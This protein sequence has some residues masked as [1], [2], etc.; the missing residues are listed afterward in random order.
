MDD[1][2]KKIIER[3]G[4]AVPD[5]QRQIM[6][7]DSGTNIFENAG[8]DPRDLSDDADDA[9]WN[10]RMEVGALDRSEDRLKA[11]QKHF[12]DAKPYGDDNFIYT[13]EKGR[14]RQYNK[15]SWLPNLGDFASIAPE[16]GE[17][18]GGAI[19]GVYG[20]AGGG[21]AGS[22]VPAVGT[23]AGTVA[24]AIGGAGAGSVVGR[25]SV[26]RGLNW[27]FG[28][29]D[30]RSGSE[31]AIDAAQT[32]A[33]GAGGEGVGRAVG[34]GFKAGKNAWN[35]SLIGEPDDIA[36][37]QQ[38][39]QDWQ[40]V[41]IDPTVGL[42]AGSDRA[43]KLEQALT[44]TRAGSDIERRLADA[45]SAQGNEFAR[46]VTGIADR[47]LSVAEAGEK[48]ADQTKLAKKAGFARSE[49]LYNRVAEK[50]TAPA[51]V[52]STDQFLKTLAAER[53]GY[54]EFDKITR[55]SQADSV[56]E[57]TSAILQ[58]AQNGMS[59]DKLK[60]ARSYIGQ[61]AND[62]E[63]KVLSKHLNGLYASLTEDMNKTAIASGPDAQQAFN[64]ANNQYRRLQDPEKGFGKGG[65]AD[66]ILKKN[67]DDVFNWAT[68][69][70]KNG[71]NRIAQVRRI[72]EKSEG[73]K[74]AWNEVVSGFTDRLGKNSADDYDPG[75]FLRAWNK[76]SEEAKDAIFK[77]SANAQYRKD[78]DTL[79]RIGDTWTKYRKNA[80]HSNTQSHAQMIRS[81]NPMDKDNAIATALGLAT[82]GPAGAALG[83]A[84]GGAGFVGTKAV[85]NSRAK[86]L[87]NPE[88]VNWIAQIPKAEMQK[89]GIAAHMQKLTAIRKRTSDQAL[90]TSINEYLR[91]LGYDE[92]E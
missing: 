83:A 70:V 72:V 78:L 21:I 52:D 29:E 71:G 84:K 86:L 77:G 81:M 30:T 76:T 58:D 40:K 42:V 17:I 59:F 2:Q 26:Q 18:M 51:V 91:D 43:A 89:G 87:T 24:G 16:Y 37:V 32:F 28:N 61:I 50:I 82:M 9:S 73:G 20:A 13:D 25:E 31:Q 35:K 34:A 53:A 62:T 38:R 64:K 6:E 11:L 27:L 92:S 15:E 47:P 46:V 14:T 88:T 45:H 5:W 75:T 48:L 68:A 4:G 63:D 65:V 39:V 41:G 57:Q 36:K 12:P 33:L 74:D 44:A 55:G 54:G 7:K 23:T 10:V 49:E 8:P 60:Q 79:S 69:G 56:I 1:W 67:T 80:N 66:T 22:A 19:G 85:Q 3:D 90:A